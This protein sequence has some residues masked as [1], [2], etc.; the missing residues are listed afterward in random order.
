RPTH[1]E[2]TRPLKQLVLDVD[3]RAQ[4]PAQRFTMLESSP[5]YVGLYPLLRQANIGNVHNLPDSN[6]RTTSV[7]SWLLFPYTARVEPDFHPNGRTFFIEAS[8][9][10]KK[11]F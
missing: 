8:Y 11:S 3:V 2:R 7:S 5:F 10:F 6:I 9:H 1:L 4:T